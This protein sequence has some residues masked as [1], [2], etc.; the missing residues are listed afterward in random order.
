M[1]I[2]EIVLVGGG[3]SHVQVLRSFGL[4]PPPGVRI[5]LIAKEVEAPYSGMIPGMVAGHYRREEAHIDLNRLARFAGAELIHGAATG[6][7]RAR[8]QVTLAGNEPVAY[9]LLSIDVGITPDL[10]GIEGADDHA[11]AVKPISRF[12]DRWNRLEAAARAPDGPRRICVVGGGAAGFE[13][14]LAARNNLTPHGDDFSFTL[15]A[16][17]ELLAG[18]NPIARW[19]ARRALSRRGV[20]L[21][22]ADEARKVSPDHIRLASGRTIAADAVL[23]STAARAPDWLTATGLPCD[24]DGFLTTRPSLQI[25]D[26]DD[27]FAVGD[28]ATVLEH[29]R[30]KAGIFAVRQGP[31]LAENL[32]LRAAGRS[33][34]PFR[35]QTRFLTLLGLGEKRAIA[36][37][38]GLAV[39]ADWAWRWKERID[40]EFMARFKDLPG[41]TME[42]ADRLDPLGGA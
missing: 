4:Q 35:P 28:C 1:S 17:G 22:E 8:R 33:A 31:P 3:H 29:P 25:V 19:L 6:I 36:A 24:K 12:T 13:L 37:R 20:G 26:D 18:S 11:I 40:R 9:D 15:V 38:N 2:R 41:E 23:V 5:T 32:R 27:V 7:D 16:G 30:P 42:D 34:Q 39:E 14:V 21:I 10:A